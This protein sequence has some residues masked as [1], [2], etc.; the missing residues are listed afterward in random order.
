MVVYVCMYVSEC[1]HMFTIGYLLISIHV[2]TYVDT[3]M[4]VILLPCMTVIRTYIR[5]FMSIDLSAATDA[6]LYQPMTIA[7]RGGCQMKTNILRRTFR[8]S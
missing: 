4:C 2:R 1:V 7:M 6:L 8:F 3:E 5:E